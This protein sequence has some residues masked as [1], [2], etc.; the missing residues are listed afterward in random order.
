MLAAMTTA[1]VGIF[2]RDNGGERRESRRWQARRPSQRGES[3]LLLSRRSR[4]EVTVVDGGG[5]A[6]EREGKIRF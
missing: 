1:E 5:G 6:Q 3:N 4:M 2:Q